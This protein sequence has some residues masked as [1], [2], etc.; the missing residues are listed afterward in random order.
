MTDKEAWKKAKRL[1]V[2]GALMIILAFIIQVV[3]NY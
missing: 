1:F 3:F 2:F